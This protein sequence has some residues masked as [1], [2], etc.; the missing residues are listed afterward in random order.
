[1]FLFLCRNRLL[2]S[3]AA[4]AQ[5]NKPPNVAQSLG[6]TIKHVGDRQDKSSRHSQRSFAPY[7]RRV[8]SV[9]DSAQSPLANGVDFPLL[10]NV[11][12]SVAHNN[13]TSSSAT[14]QS[15]AVVADSPH[16]AAP[17]PLTA[18]Q[19]Q[20]PPVN[21]AADPTMPTLSPHPP[22]K[23]NLNDTRDNQEAFSTAVK[24]SVPDSADTGGGGSGISGG[25]NILPSVGN[26]V[27]VERVTGEGSL[28]SVL[29]EH[30]DH[31]QHSKWRLSAEPKKPVLKPMFEG[32]DDEE[33]VTTSFYEY[34]VDAV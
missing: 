21:Q 15:S 12:T 22:P 20:Q 17:S 6:G 29:S 33:L 7:H 30:V 10:R 28:A 8:A 2:K 4:A 27:K 32:D 24:P 26:A 34:A 31:R 11:K 23:Q 14:L 9:R 25:K 19:A 13:T 3:R 5:S 16:S 1:M 18:T